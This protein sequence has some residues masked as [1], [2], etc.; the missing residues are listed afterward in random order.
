MSCVCAFLPVH[1]IHPE[2]PTET[3]NRPG[4]HTTPSFER[5][6]KQVILVSSQ[7]NAP[8]LRP[9]RSARTATSLVRR[10]SRP[11]IFEPRAVRDKA[12][13]VDP[14]II[15]RWF[16][17]TRTPAAINEVGHGRP[18]GEHDHRSTP[19]RDAE[20]LDRQSRDGVA[21][22]SDAA[23][24][25]RRRRQ[26][27][28]KNLL[29]FRRSCIWARCSRRRPRAMTSPRRDLCSPRHTGSRASAAAPCW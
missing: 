2:R 28:V 26:I 16:D 27:V 10:F 9:T 3:G 20:L 7:I 12:R 6:I 23:D 17:Q 24:F 21:S 22:N 13:A 8:R 11:S 15:G 19:R 1:S 25:S 14:G 4:R 29:P 18:K 5:P